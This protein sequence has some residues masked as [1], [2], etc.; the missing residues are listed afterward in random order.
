MYK[1]Q[2][3]TMSKGGQ[4]SNFQVL[5]YNV[6][7]QREVTAELLFH[8]DIYKYHV[9]AIQEPWI[10]RYI[11]SRNATFNPFPK[12][13]TAWVPEAKNPRIAFYISKDLDP[14]C[15]RVFEHSR[16]VAQVRWVYEAEPSRFKRIWITNIYNNPPENDPAVT[17]NLLRNTLSGKQPDGSIDPIFRSSD[18]QL[19]VGDFN[20][21]H[22]HWGGLHVKPDNES[23][24]LLELADEF[25]L[26]QCLPQGTITRQVFNSATTI[27]L[28][29]VSQELVNRLYY[30]DRDLEVHADSDHYPI[31]SGFDLQPILDEPAPKRCWRKTDEELFTNT[32][33]DALAELNE[34]PGAEAAINRLVK[35]LAAASEAAVPQSRPC[36]QSLPHFT[37]ECKE[38]SAICQRKRR[39]W[40]HTRTQDDWDEYVQARNHRNHLI[41]YSLRHINRTRIEK[42]GENPMGIYKLNKW[43]LYRDKGDTTIFPPIQRTAP[44]GAPISFATEPED[45]AEALAGSFFP[46]PPDADLSD[47]EGYQYPTPLNMP[48][49]TA[50]E[51]RKAITKTAPHKAPGPNGIPNYALQVSVKDPTIL[52][53]ITRAFNLCLEEGLCPTQ[54]KT[55]ITVA[56][57]KPK[58]KGDYRQVKSYRPIAL[59]DT[60]GKSL[61]S[62]LAKRISYLAAHHELLPK[63]HIGGRKATSVEHA[64]HFTLERIYGAWASENPVVSMLCLD[65]SGA[66]DNVSHE[67]LL[68]NLRKRRLPRPIVD[69]MRSFVTDR[70]TVIKLNEYKS[71]EYRTNTGIP[72]GSPLSP[73]LYLFYN[74]DLLEACNA[75]D[76]KATALGWIDDVNIMVTG[77]NAEDNV[78][79]LLKVHEGADRWAKKH[80]S[81]FAPD[82]Y[83]LIHFTNDPNK[84]KTEAAI[85]IAGH[86]QKPK[87]WVRLLGVRLDTELTWKV[88]ATH[89]EDSV[90]RALGAFSSIGSSSWGFNTLELRRLYITAILPKILF[91]CSTWYTREY[92]WGVSVTN[93]A[94]L[95]KLERLQRRGAQL[96]LGSFRTSA[97]LAMDVEMHLLPIKQSLQRAARRSLLHL[98]SNPLYKDM[99]EARL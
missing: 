45:K 11:K 96:M 50:R 41:S 36:K 70:R 67:R 61:E 86:E 10:N 24:N 79:A 37:G 58:P 88:H 48:P 19:V 53:A 15:W 16:D 38:A 14:R 44:E 35:A 63:Q 20:L 42:A 1:P 97:G 9:I 80:A 31:A 27:D 55:S 6:N 91:S 17:L 47:L 4:P 29:Y 78:Q 8:P 83:E 28:V 82:K 12:R 89:L 2:P 34:A 30:C 49:I 84:H 93:T 75:P 74:A 33:K 43:A 76:L 71:P 13:Y 5:S 51:V 25:S 18:H 87:E 99:L 65:V 7:R 3:L 95:K 23:Q 52:Q 66:F 69:W 39:N 81:V 72:Q 56:L 59:L 85:T 68:H 77:K 21:H 94:I 92:L 46:K 64:V 57:R 73:I 60:L 26:T 40:Q 32:F 54:F 98:V 22:P 62:V 90:T